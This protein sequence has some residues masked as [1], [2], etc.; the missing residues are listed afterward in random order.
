V[1]LWPIKTTSAT[2]RLT[3]RLGG[4]DRSAVQSVQALSTPGRQ[5]TSE[6]A[7]FNNCTRPVSLFDVYRF[8]RE[9]D[10]ARNDLKLPDEET[11][12]ASK[13][14][15]NLSLILSNRT[16]QMVRGVSLRSAHPAPSCWNDD[17]DLVPLH[18]PQAALSAAQRVSPGPTSDTSTTAANSISCGSR[19]L[20]SAL[21]WPRAA[22]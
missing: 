9:R 13:P 15:A 1:G 5:I 16:H 3:G 6:L 2:H 7:P 22:C 11:S 21:P 17:D 12:Q 18:E 20:A 19:R 8:E 4:L 14:I 10:P